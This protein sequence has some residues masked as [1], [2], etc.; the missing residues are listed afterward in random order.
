MH[1]LARYAFAHLVSVDKAE[2]SPTWVGHYGSIPDSGAEQHEGFH[3]L[4]LVA[5]AWH[6]IP[7][8]PLVPV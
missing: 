4:Q 3:S 5:Q 6:P 7:V 1:R 8:K 2:T